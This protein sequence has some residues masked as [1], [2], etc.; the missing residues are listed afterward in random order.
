M[1]TRS[2]SIVT[3]EVSKEQLFRLYANVNQWHEWDTDIE[4]ARL[5]GNFEQSAS[6]TLKI[7]KGPKVRI[8]LVE[9]VPNRR[10]KDLTRFPL[11][12]MYGLHTLEETPEGLK[13]TTTMQVE[14][15][16]GFFWKKVVAED[17]VKKLPVEM[18]N[19]IRE[20]K[21]ITL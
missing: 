7:R 6:F 17:I 8:E 2:H 15:P 14:G 1:W 3:R 5:E 4:Y 12:R 16:L 9:V 20:A 13:V 21:K 10:F 11:A 19:Q 18:L